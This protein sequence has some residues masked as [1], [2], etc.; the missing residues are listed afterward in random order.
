MNNKL[1][2]LIF[3]VLLVVISILVYWGT[4]KF[5]YVADDGRLIYQNT[6][7]LENWGNLKTTFVSPL[8]VKT[9]EPLPFYRPIVSLTYF[10]SYHLS[11]SL[12][13]HHLFNL[14]THIINAILLYILIFLLFKNMPL[15]VFTSLFFAALPLHESSVA[16]ISGRT[17]MVACVFFLLTM[18]LFIKRRD[19]EKLPRQ[20]LLIGAMISYILCLFSKETTLALPLFLFVLDYL[21]WKEPF[22]KKIIPYIPFVII[23]ILYLW[24]RVKVIGNLGTGEPY[25]SSGFFLRFLTVFPIYFYYF[26]KLILPVCFNYFP[27]VLTITSILDL[28]FLGSLIF[29]A[30]LLGL[31]I[32]LRR[33]TREVWVGLLWILI[34]LVPVLNLVRI[35]A[36][37]KEWWAYIPSIGF[38][39]ILG[40]LAAEGTQWERKIFEIKLPRRKGDEQITPTEDQSKK[41][42]I[43]GIK[44]PTFPDKILIKSN[45][46]FSLFFAL[47][48]IF[49]AFNI[50]SD[51]EVFR[52]EVFFWRAMVQRAPYEAVAHNTYALILQRRGTTKFAAREF[53]KA[54]QAKPDFAEAYNNLG[55][56][57]HDKGQN[58]SALVEIKEAIRLDSNYADAYANLGFIY[59]E[60]KDFVFSITA[61]QQ[62]LRLDP[63]NYS[64]YRN[65]GMVYSYIGEFSLA[66][67]HLEKAL[68]LTKSPREKK[69]LEGLIELF[70]GKA[71]GSLQPETLK[72]SD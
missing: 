47:L 72:K 60:E 10:F 22:K 27:R 26:K 67:S 11:K 39:L 32:S 5:S 61:F 3:I 13:T 64:A 59:A 33:R 6:D 15:S 2:H 70:K 53:R 55:M 65:L 34:L 23:T 41:K 28:R 48:L 19:Y 7:F 63:Q 66:I 9:Y 57:F 24:W 8:P 16:W 49:Y 58:D 52:K 1:I 37:V 68:S 44:K 25:T 46:L 36:P 21:W 14:V 29:F 62:A 56:L 35:Y 69:E 17:D 20:L 54:I 18:I 38:C 51:A 50:K 40:K 71:G 30:I 43:L 45:H 4:L 31:G 42:R 12:L